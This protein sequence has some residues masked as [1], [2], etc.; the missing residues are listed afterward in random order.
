MEHQ[1]ISI[2]MVTGDSM[3]IVCGVMILLLAGCVQ[4]SFEQNWAMFESGSLVSLWG[5]IV[6]SGGDMR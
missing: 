1:R 2:W 5:V 6:I 4:C 3:V